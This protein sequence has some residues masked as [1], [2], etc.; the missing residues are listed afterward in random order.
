MSLIVVGSIAFDSVETPTGRADDVLGGSATYF[1]YAASYFTPV[2]LVGVVGQDFPPAYRRLLENRNIDMSGLETAPGKTFRWRGAYESDMNTRRTLEVDL[3]VFG[4]FDPKLPG[5]FRDSKYVF[6]A[7]GSPAVQMKVL[8]Q[9]A[10]PA[11]VVADTMNLW[12]ETARDDLM[13]LLGK[14]DGLVLND[15]EAVMLTETPNLVAAGRHVLAWGPTFVIIKKGEHGAIL[16]T[17]TDVISLPAFPTER[18]VDPTGAGD[19]FAGGVMGYLATQEAYHE[20]HLRRAMACGT[21]VASFNVE[22]FSL[23]RF[24]VLDRSEIDRR[25]G[26]YQKML[27]I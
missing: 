4:T 25:L 27:A 8:E 22:D 1:A 5:A 23:E 21:V 20:S 2:R 10:S 24:K 3:N 15:E 13:T 7:N 6:L 12:I 17:S 11:L 26:L 18:V 14:I 16:V 9:V 19:S